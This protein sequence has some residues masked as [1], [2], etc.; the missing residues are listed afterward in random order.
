ML[1]RLAY[2]HPCVR[3]VGVRSAPPGPTV[4]Y[5][6]TR[7][8]RQ[9]LV[10]AASGPRSSKGSFGADSMESSTHRTVP[11]GNGYAGGDFSLSFDVDQATTEAS[12]FG[13]VEPAG[14]VMWVSDEQSGRPARVGRSSMSSRSMPKRGELLRPRSSRRVSVR[15]CAIE[16]VGIAGPF[17][18]AKRESRPSC[19]L[20]WSRPTAF[21][22]FASR[23]SGHSYELEICRDGVSKSSTAEDGTEL[24]IDG[25]L[26]SPVAGRYA[27][28]GT[29]RRDDW[30]ESRAWGVQPATGRILVFDPATGVVFESFPAPDALSPEHTHIGLTIADNGRTL[31]YVNADVDPTALYRLDPLT[32]EVL[33]V[34][35]I[36]AGNYGGLG[37]AVLRGPDVIYSANMDTDP[38]WTLEGDWAYGR[39]TGGGK[40]RSDVGLHGRERHRLQPQRRLRQQHADAAL[41]HD[42]SG[43]CLALRSSGALVPAAVRCQLESRRPCHHRDQCGRRELD[44]AVGEQH[45]VS[46]I[47]R[48]FC[49]NSIS[50]PSRPIS[51]KYGSAG[52]WGRPIPRARLSD[53]ISTT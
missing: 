5:G 36:A 6:S 17:Q 23:R 40:C 28:V 32:G 14:S 3:L 53:G 35:T 1:D 49:R 12:P 8:R 2:G 52:A 45:R 10:A 46:T 50:V 15:G 27:V 26:L 38:G 21:R 34:E 42:G 37:S 19:R 7:A 16:L 48:G 39:P 31:L 43:G 29:S 13:R 9:L 41:R 4:R 51:P 18:A 22:R 24:A 47:H 33:A 20:R 30:I 44:H 11:S 25:S